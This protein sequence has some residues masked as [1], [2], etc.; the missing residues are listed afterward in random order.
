[1]ALDRFAHY[2]S[3]SPILF[4]QVYVP[5]NATGEQ[6]AP[7]TSCSDPVMQYSWLARNGGS[8]GRE[9][10]AL[11]VQQAEDA[12]EAWL[13]FSPAPRWYQGYDARFARTFPGALGGSV[14]G[15]SMLTPYQLQLFGPHFTWYGGR[16]AFSTIQLAAPITYTDEDGDGYSETATVT[17]VT[18]VTDANEIALYYPGENHDPSWEVRPLKRVTISGGSAVIVFTRQQVVMPDLLESL[19]AN[20]VDGLVAGNFLTTVD[21]YRR[22]NSP[23]GMAQIEWSPAICTESA[24]TIAY[25]SG[26]ITPLDNRNGTLGV[27][28]AD[29]DSTTGDYTPVCPEWWRQPDRIKLWVRAGYKDMNLARPYVDMS[30]NLERA[31]SYLALINLDR[32]WQ[33]CERLRNLYDHLREDLAG[34]MSS[35][36]MSRSFQ[37]SKGVLDNPFGTTRAAQIAWN[38][39]RPLKVGEAVVNG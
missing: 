25:Q 2:V 19:T 17:V 37:V 12:I 14:F 9:E 38:I 21:V 24:G 36:A 30:P 16:E 11:A 13:G 10:I 3:Y 29:Y 39:V 1:M 4:N 23:D 6:R 31:I 8:P 5:D 28:A 20:A 27:V 35:P 22:Y 15:R 18:S 34:R 7:I 32:P 26:A 33:S